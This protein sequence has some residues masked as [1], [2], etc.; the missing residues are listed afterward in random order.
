[1]IEL[2]MIYIYIYHQVSLTSNETEEDAHE[3]SCV[4]RKVGWE[5]RPNVSDEV[6]KIVGGTDSGTG[7]DSTSTIYVQLMDRVETYEAY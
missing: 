7:H 4:Q 1:M 2:A 3:D 5:V 6:G